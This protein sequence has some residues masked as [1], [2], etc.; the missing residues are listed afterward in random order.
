MGEVAADHAV[1]AGTQL[2]APHSRGSPTH[3]SDVFF[4]ETDG[5]AVARDHEHVVGTGR[6][7]HPNQLVAV[8]QVDRDQTT[9][10]RRVVLRHAG[11]L[12]DAVAG[13][14]EQVHTVLVGAGIDDRF[15]VL[16]ALQRDEVH[17]RGTARGAV[18]HRDLVRARADRRGHGS[19]RTT[20]TSARSWRV[21][22]RPSP[23]REGCRR[24]RPCP[25]RAWVRN[26][27]TETVFT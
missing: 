13:G 2:H 4:G 17:Q 19:R 22:A 25:P 6:L 12:H 23:P 18:L 15:D 11:L 14:K 16:V 3:G 24:A 1:V 5:H 21:G 10:Q 8:V 26:W 27:S 20:D 9:S 7:D